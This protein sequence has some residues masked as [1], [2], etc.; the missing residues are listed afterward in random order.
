[1]PGVGH[2][3]HCLPC[4][5]RQRHQTKHAALTRAACFVRKVTGTSQPCELVPVYALN[6]A[7]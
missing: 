7:S 4:S 1:M 6:G 2:G 3:D 5:A